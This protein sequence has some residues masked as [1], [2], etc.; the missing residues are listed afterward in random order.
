[1]PAH[2]RG[3]GF[4]EAGTGL[5]A[6]LDPAMLAMA[7]VDVNAYVSDTDGGPALQ[8]RFDFPTGLLSREDVQELAD[9]W[10][11]AL[12]ALARYAVQPGAGGLTPSDVPLVTVRQGELETWE[13]QYPGLADV[14][15]L[16][17]LQ[18]GLLFQSRLAESGHDAYHVQMVHHLDGP[19]D[20]DRMRR[21]CQALLDRHPALRTAFVPGLSGDRVQ[22]V[23]D[24]VR[25]PWQQEDLRDLDD[26]ARAEALRRFLDADRQDHFDPAVP[27]LLRMALLR[28]S[29]TDA[30]LV[31]TAHHV[32]FD[33]WSLP[34]LTR[35]LMALYASEGD[36]TALPRVRGYRDF[37]AWLAD[38]DHEASAR[39]WAEEL[40]GTDEPTLL[41]V[42]SGGPYPAADADTDAGTDAGYGADAGDTGRLDVPL[43]PATA[44]DLTRR[45]AELGV[46]LNTLVQ[47]AWALVLGGLTG[48][49]DIVFGTTVSGRPPA[50]P[51]A[52]AM[53]G[54]FINTLPVRV[55]LSPWD[56]L[57]G[58]LT[59]LQGRQ[60]ALLD[61]HHVSLA[62]VQRSTG[63][64]VLFDTVVVFES[65]P[66]DRTAI[67]EAGGDAGVRVARIGSDGGTHYPFGIA[68]T[69]DPHLRIAMQ[70]R[71]P[72]VGV[73]T[74]E[75]VAGR[76]ARVLELIAA[77][78]G[79][80]LGV[81]DTLTG[82]DLDEVLAGFNDTTRE[83]ARG[84]ASG[85]VAE[86]FARQAAATPD[87]VAVHFE[88]RQLTYR[89]IDARSEALARELV[90]HGVGPE[91]VVAVSVRRSPLLV[92]ALLAVLKAGGAYLPVDPALP[93]GRIAFMAQ[94]S[95]A[96]LALVDATTADALS[97]SAI[98]ALRVDAPPPTPSEAETE[99]GP[100]V[101]ATVDNT[102]YV[103]Y[104][105]GS[106]GLPKGVAVTHRGL[107]G[108]VLS[109][110]ERL[111]FTP[112]DRML[113]LVSPSF[114][115]SLCEVFTA[116]LSGASLVMADAAEL[117]PGTPL[118]DTVDRHGVT[119]LMLTPTMLAAMP[120]GSMRGLSCLVLGGEAA[121]PDLVARWTP[122]RRV[123]NV[124][125]PT[126]A[127]VCATMSLPLTGDG[128]A[129]PIGRPV[130]GTRLYV[131]DG[132]LR[133][134]PPGVA[135]ELY[136]AGPGLARGYTGRAALTAGRFVASPF[137]APGER[138]YRTGDVVEWTGD[139]DLLFRGRTDEQVK[140]RGFRIELGEIEAALRE[141]P[142]I[143]EAVVVVDTRTGDR[144]LAGYVVPAGEARPD[145]ADLARHLRDRLPGHMVPP[146]ILVIDE[147]PL[148]AS[149]KLDRR[150][151]PA[152]ETART[153]AGRAPQSTREAI[154]CGLFA[155]VLGAGPV[156]P[157]DDFFD[158]G[159]HSLLVNRLVTRIRAVLGVEVPLRVVFQSPT[160]AG[161]A[162]RLDAHRGAGA[163]SDAD[164]FAPVL[165]VKGDGDREP[166][167]WV[168]PGGGLSWPYLGFAGLLPK[169]RPVYGLQAK[170]FDGSTPLPGSVADMVD[171][172][173][174]EVLAVQPEGPFHLMGLSSGG[175]LAHAMAA[176]LRRRGHEVGLVA[177]LDSVPSSSLAGRPLPTEAEFRDYFAQHLTGAVGADDYE[178]LVE[179][180]VRIGLN[181]TALMPGF[182]VPAFDSDVLLF[183]AVPKPEGTYAPLWA[184]H[185]GGTVRRH[186]VYAAHEDLYLPGPAAEICAVITRELAGR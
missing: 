23:V 72:L 164:P 155:E 55:R 173:V 161:L 166:L 97:A 82:P 28:T 78:P 37:L 58:M 124:Y 100:G 148:T 96:R 143:R 41:A 27:P 179:T 67:A 29:D 171:D 110:V 121:A 60:A 94:D 68:A 73:R 116:L 49:R 48:R 170:G 128:G 64:P 69:A 141:L 92:T 115:V 133:P 130:A 105:S 177:L 101:R 93:A 20:P 159:G 1:M 42:G 140:I 53:V 162:A 33:G 79:T 65:F 108:L 88:G 61:H 180:A 87:A 91:T 11:T 135:G 144:R 46:T 30:R 119:H 136:I 24:G 126:E 163:A 120:D 118:A 32:L 5:T 90:R 178:S 54:L 174:A 52:D 176:E 129:R 153:T 113:Q 50:V 75:D 22:L 8:A 122:G 183:D 45:A 31:L 137:G 89:E 47:G 71:Q 44:R 109:H 38:Q 181:Y 12:E 114:D 18:E 154:L 80:P 142:D 25:L 112:A 152:P 125:G 13:K 7:A 83:T 36:A 150:A 134:V 158:L 160:A 14:W 17:G 43:D 9:L 95:G 145:P 127:T 2:L 99:A 175:T 138:M 81:L 63:L 15:P 117:V 146:S 149:R 21:A 184:P 34:L 186:P 132:A 102:A 70:Y 56:T 77:D 167:W 103:I 26:E 131:L 39:A 111:A 104:T 76:F 182:P 74:A 40:D 51:D 123:V 19:V 156:A 85:T 66:V 168:H 165:T 185:V 10:H 107:A 147:V 139:G 157:T 98:P 169:D 4:T 106:T 35:D 84:T 59:A 151:L 62:D 57:G 86:Q 6:A 172:Y 16:T 3:E